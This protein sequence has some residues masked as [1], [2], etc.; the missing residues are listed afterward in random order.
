M[1]ERFTDMEGCQRGAQTALK[2][3]SRHSMTAF[4]QLVANYGHTLG[5][6]EDLTT[7]V[8]L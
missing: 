1:P 4:S 8:G 5:D 3:G 2:V 7:S 6:E